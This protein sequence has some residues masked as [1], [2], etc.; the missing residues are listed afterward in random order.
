MPLAKIIRRIALVIALF[1]VVV[2]AGY[3]VLRS[4]AFHRYVIGQVNQK[5]QQSTGGRSETR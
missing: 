1:I 4:A 2:I 5:I 3:F